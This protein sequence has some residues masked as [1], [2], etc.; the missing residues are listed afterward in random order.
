MGAEA[1][2]GGRNRLATHTH[3]IMLHRAEL[4]LRSLY[5]IIEP[6]PPGPDKGY[7]NVE[8]I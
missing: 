1:G 6:G 2:V 4:P 5:A 8:R 3:T 7:E